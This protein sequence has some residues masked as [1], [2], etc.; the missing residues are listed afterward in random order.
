MARIKVEVRWLRPAGAN[1]QYLPSASVCRWFNTGK[2]AEEWLTDEWADRA[3]CCLAG[4][5]DHPE[6]PHMVIHETIIT[7]VKDDEKV[8]G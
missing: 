4:I 6:I 1:G 3:A 5:V 8:G 2:A 7:V